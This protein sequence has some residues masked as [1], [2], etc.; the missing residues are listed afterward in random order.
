MVK[1][2]E[3]KVK[4]KD[5]ETRTREDLLAL[6]K[7]LVGGTRVEPSSIADP[8]FRVP[9]SWAIDMAGKEGGILIIPVIKSVTVY[10]S[11]HYRQAFTLAEAYEKQTGER[12]TLEKKYR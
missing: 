7:R 12:W 5:L 10:D 3:E 2:V 1:I 6:T 9:F 4:E 8:D 11:D